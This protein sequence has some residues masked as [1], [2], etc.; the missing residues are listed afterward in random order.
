MVSKHK[1]RNLRL[2]ISSSDPS[3]I[4]M[5]SSAYLRCVTPPP[6]IRCPTTPDMWLEIL[7]FSKISAKTSTA[8]L[9]RRGDMGS[10][11]S[12]HRRA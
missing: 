8:A 9:K 1:R 6:G 12:R 11:A 3:T 5:V 4:I 7:A 10:P 2:T